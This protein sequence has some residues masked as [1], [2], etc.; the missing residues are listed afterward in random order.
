MSD[1]AHRPPL[2]VRLRSKVWHALARYAGTH[3]CAV[4]RRQLTPSAVT[5]PPTGVQVRL[6]TLEELQ[7]YTGQAEYEL[8]DE[9]LT[10][11]FANGHAAVLTFYEYELAAYGWISY[12]RTR[13]LH[14]WSVEFNKEHRYNYKNLTLPAY[15][16]KRLRGSFGVLN[17]R[18]AQEGVTHSIAFIDL[19]NYASIR[20]EQRNGGARVGFA[21]FVDLGAWH[22]AFRSPGAK[23][24]G[25]RFLRTDD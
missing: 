8:S 18:D 11:A 7:S 23:R 13:H 3:V 21:G 16:G 17:A 19:H 9:F 20:A 25:L 10:R 4:Y 15:R 24:V 1:S 22:W 5:T 12:G 14:G 2:F 6:G